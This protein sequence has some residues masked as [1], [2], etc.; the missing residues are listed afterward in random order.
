MLTQ[1]ERVL[2]I[3]QIR[4]IFI[5]K[6]VIFYYKRKQQPK[7]QKKRPFKINKKILSPNAFRSCDHMGCLSVP[8]RK[9]I[10]QVESG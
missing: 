9:N 3:L 8:R 1:I 5:S 10:L 4:N 7:F 6:Y 2:L